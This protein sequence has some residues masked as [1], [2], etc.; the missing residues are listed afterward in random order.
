[1]IPLSLSRS[2][3]IV[4]GAVTVTVAAAEARHTH[5]A[6]HMMRGGD[7]RLLSRVTAVN[8]M[9]AVFIS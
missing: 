5:T 7:G 3:P 1:M 6:L 8:N 9:A 4:G 2:L